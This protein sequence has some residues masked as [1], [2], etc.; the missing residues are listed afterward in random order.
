MKT[1]AFSD[2]SAVLATFM[3]ASLVST[4]LLAQSG[5]SNAKAKTVSTEPRSVPLKRVFGYY[6]IYLALPPEGRDGF[7]MQ[8]KINLDPSIA[9]PQAY[10]ISGQ[11]RIPMQLSPSG[12]V[13]NMPNEAMYSNG[14][15]E[16]PAGSPR[17]SINMDLKPIVPLSRAIA[18][19]AATNPINDYAGAI[20]RAGPLALMAPKLTGI[21]FVGSTSGEVVFTDGRRAALPAAPGGGVMFKPVSPAMRGAASLSFATAPVSVEFAQ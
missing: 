11:T 18:V 15:L 8:Y 1:H 17:T 4:P 9:R 21:R 19:A 5:Q 3:C 10:Y 7:V 2:F 14:S 6:D 16:I 12:V 13:L 20:R